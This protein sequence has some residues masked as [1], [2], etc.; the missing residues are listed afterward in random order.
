MSDAVALV[1]N[2][3]N[4]GFRICTEGYNHCG[5][6]PSNKCCENMPTRLKLLSSMA[7]VRERLAVI[8]GMKRKRIP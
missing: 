5:L 8:E 4:G 3:G 1:S 2:G 7:A 6:Q